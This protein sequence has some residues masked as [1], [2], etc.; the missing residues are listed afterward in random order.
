[1]ASRDLASEPARGC[2]YAGV[3]DRANESPTAK[4]LVPSQCAA[5]TKFLELYG[6]V[7]LH[8]VV[9]AG[10]SGFRALNAGCRFGWRQ[11]QLHHAAIQARA[12]QPQQLGRPAL[13]SLGPLAERARSVR[14]PMRAREFFQHD[15]LP[16]GRCGPAPRRPPN[17]AAW[18]DRG[19]DRAGRPGR[20]PRD[21]FAN[22]SR[23]PGQA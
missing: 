18:A 4:R 20:G 1:M 16:S 13:V 19:A 5:C 23:L 3:I 17:A 7:C 8:G 2:R 6:V 14:A 21:H 22:S 12:G 15:R 10:S 9:C 11:A